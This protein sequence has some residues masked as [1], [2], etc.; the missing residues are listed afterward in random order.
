MKTRFT[1]NEIAHVWAHK[2]AP[3]GKSPGAMSF[4]GDSFYSYST[5]IARHLTHKGKPAIVV[6]DRSFS[7]TTSAHQGKVRSAIHG[8]AVPVFY[9]DEGMGASLRVTGKELFEYAVEQSIAEQGKASRA[10]KRKDRHEYRA[11]A[12]LESAKQINVFFGLRRK[13]DEK[14]I[15]RLREAGER[16]EREA[17]RKRAEAEA[18]QR[19]KE[20]SEY[21]KWI[22]GLPSG[23][24]N[25]NIHP[26]AFR[27]EG[28]ELVSSKG[29]RVP[30][31]AA[32]VA[33]RFVMK[34]RESGWHRNGS[35]CQVGM[36]HLDAINPQGVV[37][38]CHR[39]TWDEVERVATLLESI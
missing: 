8:L 38:G 6:N 36:Y 1:S 35:T 39:I 27:I 7:I 25:P 26:I 5:V 23:Y 2:S 21:L 14:T 24:F 22:G 29:A 11:A 34:H 4:D 13:V 37:A 20:C 15:E 12:W 16:A 28:A 19:A 32:K 17:A 30:L 9:F 10:R 18:A 3:H 33:V 31:E